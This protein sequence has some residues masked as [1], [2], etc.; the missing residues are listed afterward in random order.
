MRIL[1]T[2]PGRLSRSNE[3]QENIPELYT[4]ADTY[5]YTIFFYDFSSKFSTINY[6]TTFIVS[7]DTV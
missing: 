3:C 7:N 6:G 1:Y 4:L 2:L 5:V